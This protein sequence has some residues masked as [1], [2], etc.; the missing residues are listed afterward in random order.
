MANEKFLDAFRAL[1]TELKLEGCSVLD[2]ENS[3]DEL[4]RERLKVCRIMR[5]YMA[6]NDTTFLSTT[7]DQIKFLENQT[8][9]IRRKAHT[10]KDETKKITPLKATAPI[11][12]VIA[13]LAKYPVAVLE[14][15]KVGFYL[16]DKDILIKNLA[17]GN[18]KIAVP[19]KIPAYNY[20][21]KDERV[22]GVRKGVYIVTND[23][24]Y[25]GKY[26]GIAIL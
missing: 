8:M 19:A 11:K 2:H 1:D 13:V 14:I 16:V 6:H 22:L 7:T 26:L 9:Q 21:S 12:D 3:L 20:I 23:G 25:T 4:S 17:A 24:M 5:N 18:K 10:I 15:P